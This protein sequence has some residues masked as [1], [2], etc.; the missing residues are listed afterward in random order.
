M[1]EWALVVAEGLVK[2][3]ED[4]RRLTEEAAREGATGLE[5]AVKDLT[6]SPRQIGQ[7]LHL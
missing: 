6:A 5:L 4:V 1:G 7:L 2:A 3:E